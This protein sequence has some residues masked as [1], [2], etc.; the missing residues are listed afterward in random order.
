M[1]LSM[2]RKETLYGWFY[3]IFQLT[4]L[5]ALLQTGNSLLPVPLS[6]AVLNFLF[7]LLNFLAVIL[8]FRDFLRKNLKQLSAAP[9]KALQYTALGAGIL[10][11]CQLALEGLLPRIRPDY[12]NQNDQ[13]IAGLLRESFPLITIGTVLLVPPVEESFFR[14]L[15]FRPLRQRRRAGAYLLSALAFAGIHMLGFLGTYSPAELGL[16]L[17]QYLP[18]GLVLAWAYE[19]SGTIFV[20]MFIHALVNIRA[21][22]LMR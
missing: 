13:V 16:A 19:R 20:P 11:L 7:F 15:I 6:Q 2:S 22:W 5:P 18:A 4:L 17:M 21:I 9:W 8:I 3:W 1:N 10:L 14:G 12:A